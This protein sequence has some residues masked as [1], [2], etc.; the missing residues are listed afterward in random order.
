MPRRLFRDD[1]HREIPAEDAFSFWRKEAYGLLV[2]GAA[3]GGARHPILYFFNINKAVIQRAAEA[4]V[5]FT[6]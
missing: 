6:A 3:D 2:L 4:V 5:G 1:K